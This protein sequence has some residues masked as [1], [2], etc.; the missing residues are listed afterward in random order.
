VEGWGIGG[1]GL[2]RGRGAAAVEGIP[3]VDTH[4]VRGHGP[5]PPSPSPH[6]SEVQRRT[7]RNPWEVIIS[8]RKCVAEG[9]GGLLTGW[10]MEVTGGLHQ[11]NKGENY[12]VGVL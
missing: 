1:R 4:P 6:P 12:E 5:L 7:R 3:A 11:N 9:G 10:R 8:T 2:G